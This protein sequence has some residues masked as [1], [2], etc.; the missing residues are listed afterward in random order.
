MGLIYKNSTWFFRILPDFRNLPISKV[1]KL[2]DL[3]G[4]SRPFL[5][6]LDNFEILKF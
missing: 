4:H 5:T 3:G 6:F 1:G 2:D